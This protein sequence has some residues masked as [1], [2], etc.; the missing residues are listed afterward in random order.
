M[1]EHVGDEPILRNILVPVPPERAFEHFVAEL[2]AWW[3]SEYTW[4]GNVLERI[5][6]EPHHGGP[7]FELGPHGFRCDWGRVLIWDPPDRLVFSW[8]I[9]P[10]RTPEPDP[11]K[12]SEV[13][14]RFVADG[15]DRTRVELVHRGFSRHGDGAA[16]YRD[17]LAAPEGWTYILNRYTETIR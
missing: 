4:S 15:P 16:E 17:G 3:P 2:H 13:E 14:V 8:Q 12:A 10:D 1:S 11:D 5:G 9:G 6:I 7:C